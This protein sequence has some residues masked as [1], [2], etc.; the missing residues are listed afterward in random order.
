MTFEQLKENLLTELK[1]LGG[2]VG[3]KVKFLTTG[4]EFTFNEDLQF[5][6]ASVIKIPIAC[7][8]YRQ[9]EDGK[10]NEKD[11]T[12]ITEDNYVEGSGITRLLDKEDTF[13]FRD[14]V[15]LMLTIS[16][17]TATNQLVD[18]VGWEAIEAY[19]KKLGL[20][21]TTFRHKMMIKAGRGPN[22]TTAKD[23][24]T[25]LEKIYRSDI[26]GSAKI[27]EILKQQQDRRRIPL[28]LPNDV[29]I[30]HKP[31]SLEKA[32]HDVGIIYAK[33]P[34]IFAFFS[35]DQEDKNLT[36]EVLSTCAKLCYTYSVN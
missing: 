20:S 13:T 7:E 32:V 6:A 15:V 33:T 22:F 17:N 29:D 30:A 16:D 19:M 31:G 25:L 9:V 14:L 4:E 34:F 18:A 35:D 5:W 12:K 1:T 36:N 2:E 26:P 3:V 23:T 24:T 28:Y 21:N 8:F 11:K 27:L 10:L